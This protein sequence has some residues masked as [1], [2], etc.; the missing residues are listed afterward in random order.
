MVEH[1]KCMYLNN[2]LRYRFYSL[3]FLSRD[4]QADIWLDMMALIEK[5]RVT[6]EFD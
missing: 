4:R 6:N 3:T 2:A 1:I 5:Y